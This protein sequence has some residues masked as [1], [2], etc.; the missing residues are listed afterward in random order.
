MA[1]F[2]VLQ[3]GKISVYFLSKCL[4]GTQFEKSVEF[5]EV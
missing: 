3:A 2:F 5:T 4:I 1:S